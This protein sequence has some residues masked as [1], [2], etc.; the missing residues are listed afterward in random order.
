MGNNII[1]LKN[2][3]RLTGLLY[4]FFA[5]IAIYSYMYMGQQ[6]FVKG[7]TAGTGKNMLVNEFLFRTGLAADIITTI[8]FVTVIIFLYRLLKHINETQARLMAGIA[9]VAIPVSFIGQALQLTALFIFKG[10]L[11]KSFPVEQSQDIAAMLFRIGNNTGQ[12]VTFNWGLWLMPMGWLVYQSGFIPR[13]LGILLWINGIGY[14][15]ASITFVLFPASVEIV[16]KI[17]LPTYFIGE[18]P[19]LLWLSIKG[20]K[21]KSLIAAET[22]T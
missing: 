22:A 13:L 21:T 15:T 19:L 7:D 17:V 8:L 4:L 5:L 12:L 6:I 9:A 3:A 11:L 18:L 2:T 10:D 14:I 16:S 1:S 20:I